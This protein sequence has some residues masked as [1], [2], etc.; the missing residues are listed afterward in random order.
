MRFGMKICF[1]VALLAA[2]PT[3]A[4]PGI[5][6]MGDSISTGAASHPALEYH[7]EILWRALT[8]SLSVKASA[9]DIPSRASFGIGDDIAPPTRLWPARRENDGASGWVWL[10]TI[11]ALSRS[12]LDTE[13]YSYGYL[14]GRALG[15]SPQDIIIA[16]D[17]GTRAEHGVLHADRLIAAGDGDLPTRILIFYTGND[18]CA[19]TWEDMTTADDYGKGT[20]RTIE[21]LMR[22]G[23]ADA[24]GTTIYIPG[25][26]SVTHLLHDKSILAKKIKVY[27]ETM[28]CEEARKR[29]FISQTVAVDDKLADDWRFMM[30]AQ[31]MPPNP[32]LL[33]PTVFS[34]GAQ[35]PAKQGI[36]AN[37]IRAYREA[38]QKAVKDANAWISQ[39]PEASGFAVKYISS[40]ESIAFQ[41]EDVAGDCFHLSPSG[42]A[43]VANALLP[44]MH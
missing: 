27:G 39:H 41:G 34:K 18:L 6:I 31:F 11:Q 3:F 19:Q 23:R 44:S 25:F 32:A 28:T 22:N 4:R 35:D 26:L 17:N 30:F 15:V 24:G 42:Q 43:K 29:M 9:A 7:P 10:H 1:L 38:Q 8:G 33:C 5:A 13:E 37:R 14:S 21:Y 36:L 12:L 40:T 16:G 2:S 20:L